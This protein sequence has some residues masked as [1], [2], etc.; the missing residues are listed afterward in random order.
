MESFQP[1]VGFED[2]YKVS[3]LGNVLGVK[4]NKLLKQK[5]NVHG[6]MVLELT[7][8]NKPYY[9][10]VHRLVAM[11]FIPNFEN[12][13]QVNH[14]NGIKTDN[15]VKNLEWS[16]SKQNVAHAIATGLRSTKLSSKDVKDIRLLKS[17]GVSSVTLGK[18]FGISRQSII[19]VVNGKAHDPDGSVSSQHTPRKSKIADVREDILKDLASGISQP[20]LALKY[21]VSKSAISQVNCGKL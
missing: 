9:V 10:N 15:R 14:I 11:A 17:Q 16:T 2:L 7:K 6:Y 21:G 19:Q 20:K 5:M 4:R 12:L 1:V 3:D 18:M 13:P 8:C